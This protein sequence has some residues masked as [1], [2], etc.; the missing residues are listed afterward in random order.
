LQFINKIKKKLTL[1]RLTFKVVYFFKILRHNKV[2]KTKRER[3]IVLNNDF[4]NNVY[5][6]IYTFD[7]NKDFSIYRFL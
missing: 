6:I 3:E 4:V 1:K 5:V 7:K 2:T